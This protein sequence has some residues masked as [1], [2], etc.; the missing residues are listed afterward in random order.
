MRWLERGEGDG[1]EGRGGE[2]EKE[3]IPISHPCTCAF[4]SQRANPPHIT[5]TPRARERS[6]RSGRRC[7][8]Y[9]KLS[10]RSR[11]GHPYLPNCQ[12]RGDNSRLAEAIQ[13]I[14]NE[15]C[16]GCCIIAIL[17]VARREKRKRL[18][19]EDCWWL[20]GC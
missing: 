18:C 1:E 6:G 8:R 12:A 16:D 2:G 14:E 9:K 4:Y 19:S 20:K 3:D 13:R 10:F 7:G 17:I 15:Q 5:R 11:G